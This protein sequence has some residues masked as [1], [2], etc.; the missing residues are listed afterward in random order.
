MGSSARL[1]AGD[2]VLLELCGS[3]SLGGRL[4]LGLKGGVGVG[5]EARGWRASRPPLHW[6]VGSWLCFSVA[7]PYICPWRFHSEV[8]GILMPILLVRKLRSPM[9]ADLRSRGWPGVELGPQNPR[10][11]PFLP[12][13]TC[14]SQERVQLGVGG[15]ES[16]RG[17]WDLVKNPHTAPAPLKRN[18]SC[19]VSVRQVLFLYRKIC[20]LSV[21]GAEQP[22][23]LLWL[24]SPAQAE[25]MTAVWS[26]AGGGMAG[27]W[28]TL[29]T[30]REVMH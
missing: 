11:V 13:P 19:G 23:C 18:D 21:A 26:P 17:T 25:Q 7:P 6:L 22:C 30:L 1:C 16:F 24:L 3:R 12:F 2:A 14:W 29:W 15:M 5:T 8:A 27:L 4:G 10:P 28:A 9:V 20:C